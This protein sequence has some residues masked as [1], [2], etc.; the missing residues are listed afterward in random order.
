M[1]SLLLILPTTKNAHCTNSLHWLYR[2]YKG[3]NSTFR[4][5]WVRFEI[6]LL[7]AN[8][9]HQTAQFSLRPSSLTV[10]PDFPRL[11]LSHIFDI[12]E[13]FSKRFELVIWMNHLHVSFGIASF[14]CLFRLKFWQHLLDL[15]S[16]WDRK[17]YWVL[18]FFI[19]FLFM[20]NLLIKSMRTGVFLPKS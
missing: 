17:A 12:M 18:R 14:C 3:L 2:F 20:G 1:G 15:S 9:F 7:L 16:I 13:R 10:N 6:I 4:P 5:I 19:V 8:N 11:T